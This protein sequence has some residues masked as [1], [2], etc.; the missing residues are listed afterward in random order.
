MWFGINL[1][2][3]SNVMQ[4]LYNNNV[5]FPSTITAADATESEEHSIKKLNR[6]YRTKNIRTSSREG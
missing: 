2:S 6:L 4:L 1:G 3:K 5:L